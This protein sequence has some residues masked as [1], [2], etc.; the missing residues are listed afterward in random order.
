MPHPKHKVEPAWRY[1]KAQDA[2]LA[3]EALLAQHGIRIQ[4]G[5]PLETHVLRVM[6]LAYDKEEGAAAEDPDVRGTYRTLIG[7]HELASHIL[8][9]RESPSFPSLVPHLRILNDGAALQNVPSGGG[10]QATNKLFELFAASLAMQCGTNVTLDDP[11]AS[12]GDNPDVLATLGGRRWGIA[13]KVLHSLHPEGFIRHLEKGLE[14]IDNS[15]A[16]IGVVLFNLKNVLPH[17]RIWPLAE[18]PGSGN[19]PNLGPAAWPNAADPYH[20]LLDSLDSLGNTLVSYLPR[21][22]LDRVFHGRKRIPGFL[23]WAHSVS[24]VTIDGRPTPTSVRALNFRQVAPISTD[25]NNVLSCLN[26]AAFLSSPMR[27]PRPIC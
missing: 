21:D 23:L 17:D 24:A 3:L 19:P 5:G 15:P 6:K 8:E 18:I 1:E 13:C 26:W 7:V 14:Q 12:T 20:I 22:Y 11:H 25:I 27:G 9:V 4:S 16:D 10:D 2:A